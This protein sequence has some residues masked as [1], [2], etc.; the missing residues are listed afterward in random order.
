MNRA[1]RRCCVYCRVSPMTVL[2]VLHDVNA[3]GGGRPRAEGLMHGG[4]RAEGEGL[5]DVN[6][7]VKPKRCNCTRPILGLILFS[8]VSNKL[9]M[10]RCPK[11]CEAVCH[12]SQVNVR[13]MTYSYMGR[14]SLTSAAMLWKASA[15]SKTLTQDKEIIRIRPT[16]ECCRHEVRVGS[17]EH[18]VW[19]EHYVNNVEPAGTLLRTRA[20]TACVL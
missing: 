6:P 1:E 18:I 3:Q 15:P 20:G 11:C 10:A 8:H 5:P 13:Q 2:R 19:A 9:D 14:M 7:L 16:C 4:H 17:G 12:N